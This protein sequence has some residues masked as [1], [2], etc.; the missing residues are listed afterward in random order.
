VARFD[1]HEHTF[2]VQLHDAYPALAHCAQD[3]LDN[4]PP[5]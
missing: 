5:G 1:E 2:L 4:A 3:F